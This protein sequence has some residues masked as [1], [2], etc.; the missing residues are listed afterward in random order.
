MEQGADMPEFG[1]SAQGVS[2]FFL[3][4]ELDLATASL[5]ETTVVE[6]VE[7]G[8]P[9]TLDMTAVSFVDSSGLRSIV[10]LVNALPSGCIILHGVREEVAKV[11]ALVGLEQALPNL[12][13]L[14]CAV[15]ATEP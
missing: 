13:V 6:A 11:I 12:Y 9:I 14:P 8:G 4:G 3:N 2:T 15:K 5:F 1:I 7:R 10:R